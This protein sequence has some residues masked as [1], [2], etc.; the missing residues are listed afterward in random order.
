MEKHVTII[1]HRK[2][3][4]LNIHCLILVSEVDWIPGDINRHL[5]NPFLCGQSRN[6]SFYPVDASYKKMKAMQEVWVLAR[7]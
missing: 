5:F 2:M 4:Q 6:A 7:S 3:R 1:L